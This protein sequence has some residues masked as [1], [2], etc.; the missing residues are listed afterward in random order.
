M[1][2]L[3]LELVN[4]CIKTHLEIVHSPIMGHASAQNTNPALRIAPLIESKLTNTG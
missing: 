3:W 2:D 1:V 4:R